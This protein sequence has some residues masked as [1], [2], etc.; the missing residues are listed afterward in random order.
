MPSTVS[1]QYR[2]LVAQGEIE[3]DAAQEAIAARLARLEERLAQHRLSRKSSHLGW[4]F[5]KKNP[6]EPIKGLYIHGDVGRGKTMLMDLFFAA[7]AVKRKRRAHFHEFMAEVH[8]RVH[9]YR[10]KIK[11]G[12]ITDDDPIGL[13]A[14]ALAEEAW[15][16]CFDEFH[17]TDIADAMI[18]GRL[19][20]AAVRGGRRGRGHLERRAR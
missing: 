19:V 17:V 15:L 5:A 11:S 7:S 3:R 18:L 6:A 1:E 9:A 16:L 13:T 20:H 4:L 12:E 10:Q 14:A 2:A 8:E